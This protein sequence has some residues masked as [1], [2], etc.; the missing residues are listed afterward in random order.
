MTE[1]SPIGEPLLV[2]VWAVFG[3]GASMFPIGLMLGADCS[4]C[5]TF[6]R[7]LRF[8]AVSPPDPGRL[9][10]GPMPMAGFSVSIDERAEAGVT[11]GE[12]GDAVVDGWSVAMPPYSSL[13]GEFIEFTQLDGETV[14]Q[15][16]KGNAE[17]IGYTDVSGQ[18]WKVSI[19][20]PTPFCGVRIANVLDKLVAMD[21]VSDAATFH[22]EPVEQ[23]GACDI[24]SPG[25]VRLLLAPLPAA[26]DFYTGFFASCVLFY[27]A[28]ATPEEFFC[29]DALWAIEHGRCRDSFDAIVGGHS[30]QA[31]LI[32]I[33]EPLKQP[34]SLY[35][36][37]M[38]SPDSSGTYP[39]GSGLSAAVDHT[40]DMK[41]PATEATVTIA[42]SVT[43][44]N[45]TQRVG[46]LEAGDY[47]LE[48]GGS[49]NSWG[50]EGAFPLVDLSAEF[51]GQEI[52]A[53]ISVTRSRESFCDEWSEVVLLPDGEAN[54]THL[55]EN[56]N[57]V[58][59][60]NGTATVEYGAHSEP[61]G[62]TVEQDTTLLPQEG[63]TFSAEFCCPEFNGEYTVGANDS[64]LESAAI[65]LIQI[66]PPPTGS[67]LPSPIY[68]ARTFAI[69]EAGEAP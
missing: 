2:L 65:G 11:Y 8:E 37:W 59:G 62:Y 43:Y 49:C 26:G 48:G 51:V 40:S 10:Y 5:C 23:E 15:Y 68:A 17:I 30:Y 20:L 54:P 41:C 32:Q 55:D 33:D 57:V 53:S 18:A 14:M 50:Y 1:L 16:L 22:P 6:R 45:A 13:A 4:D 46:V 3:V 58:P 34:A 29:G 61:F 31:G 39:Q 12:D 35:N 42:D 19:D 24:P 21:V 9:T 38:C 44:W 7:C 66:Q 52:L 27:S 25:D 67:G 63:G 47:V 28:N 60:W 56:E 64:G 69:I 36:D